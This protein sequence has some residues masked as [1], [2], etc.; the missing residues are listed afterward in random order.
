MEVLGGRAGRGKRHGEEPDPRAPH[1]KQSFSAGH[2]FHLRK[3]RMDHDALPF[4]CLV[5]F[6]LGFSLFHRLSSYP[7]FYLWSNSGFLKFLLLTKIRK[8]E[9]LCFSPFCNLDPVRKGKLAS[10]LQLLHVAV[11]FLLF[12]I[13]LSYLLFTIIQQLH[14]AAS[15]NPIEETRKQT[16]KREMTCLR[17][18]KW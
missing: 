15:I 5:S 12:T 13:P 4:H 10:P 16:Q 7:F 6:H 18:Y 3:L 2:L 11:S 9:K 8:D 14:E 1:S 17:P